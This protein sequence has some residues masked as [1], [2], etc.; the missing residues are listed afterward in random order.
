MRGIG[1]EA[2]LGTFQVL[3]HET[4][5]SGGGR[6]TRIITNHAFDGEAAYVRVGVLHDCGQCFESRRLPERRQRHDHLAADF[7]VG[8]LQSVHQRWDDGTVAALAQLPGR[9]GANLGVGAFQPLRRERRSL[10]DDQRRI[11]RG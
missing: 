3:F 10:G 7:R 11:V 5:E 6:F 1:A 9:F 4:G 8:V 2:A